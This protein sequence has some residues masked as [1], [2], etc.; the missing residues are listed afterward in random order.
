MM[1]GSL[2]AVYLN[3]LDHIYNYIVAIYKSIKFNFN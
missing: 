2:I 1:S 3:E